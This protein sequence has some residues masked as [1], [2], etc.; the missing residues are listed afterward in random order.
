MIGKHIPTPKAG[1]SFRRLNS[2]ILSDRADDASHKVA[3]SNAINLS[4]VETATMEMEALAFQNKRCK[5]PVFHCLLSWKAGEQ[6]S[7]DQVYDAVEITLKE[8]GLSDCQAL[9]ALH[10][11]TENYHVHIA[12]NRVSPETHKA[13]DPAHGWTR[14]AMERSARK[15]EHEQGWEIENNAWTSIDKNGNT[16]GE[17]AQVFDTDKTIPQKVKD[18]EN[19]TG[20]KSAIR[21]AKEII[22]T[23]IKNINSWHD[24]H[25]FMQDKNLKYERKGS[26]AII[27][28][29][30]VK[31]KASSVSKNLSL[32][33]LEKR[34]GHF[35]QYEYRDK[36]TGK[37]HEQKSLH[38]INR[39]NNWEL[40]IEI[41]KEYYSNKKMIND[42]LRAQNIK[43]NEMLKIRQKTEREAINRISWKGRRNELNYAR[44]TLAVRQKTE[45]LDLRDS[46]KKTRKE[47]NN[48]RQ[49][50]PSYEEWLRDKNLVNDAEKWRYRATYSEYA[51]I[52]IT[53]NEAAEI[54]NHFRDI[55][56]YFAT[57]GRG[58][59]VAFKSKDNPSITAF[60][61]SGRKI[62]VKVDDESAMLAAMQLAQQKWGA[63]QLNGSDRYKEK[64]LVLAVENGIQI[65]N[66]ELQEKVKLLEAEIRKQR[67]Q[68]NGGV[69]MDDMD[70]KREYFMRYHT[71]VGADRYKVTATEIFEDGTK[72]GFMVNKKDGCPDGFTVDELMSKMWRLSSLESQGRNIYYTP[73]S[74]DKHHILIDD[75]DNESLAKFLSDGY[76]AA[77]VIES[78]PGN[79]QAVITIDKLGS[80]VD[81][82]VGNAIV[83]KLNQEY[84]DPSVS[85]EIHAHRAPGFTNRKRKH[86]RE[87][88]TFPEVV[89]SQT[90]DGICKKTQSLAKEILND[91]ITM[92]KEEAKQFKE[93]ESMASRSKDNTTIA[94]KIHLEDVLKIQQ[95]QGLN[96][97]ELDASRVDAMICIRLRATGHN[98]DDI[99]KTLLVMAPKVREYIGSAGV[100]IWTDYAK[101]TADYAFG[102]SGDLA[103]E[104]RK[105]FV[106]QWRSLENE[107]TRANRRTL[108]KGKRRDTGI[109]R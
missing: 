42:E 68:R 49:R 2:Y 36:L 18:I 88:G 25:R 43:I 63:V 87:D 58:G 92:Q 15:I 13:I 77:A 104:K 19:L 1:S 101:R 57:L 50:F 47:M 51:A 66:P 108:G 65:T 78:S 93:L 94:Y 54:Y 3:Y 31:I 23:E 29:G 53:G 75:M 67:K 106:Q 27:T 64:C 11:N 90:N 21:V 10:K 56:G 6:P 72:R 30:D 46:Q 71:A 82:A 38:D 74:D 44:S 69:D 37:I 24:L 83:A 4:S 96:K 105:K 7:K 52:V 97:D 32:T 107:T 100:H 85:G 45:R 59:V 109:G 35:E 40:Y 9:F 5:D 14:K 103:L 76:Q 20:E 89:L 28:V 26:G 91:M 70:K 33:S 98:K 95:K 61:D 86:C 22:N 60:L 8:L 84:G 62:T 73:I 16:V 80:D 17:S 12:V 34:F 102:Y 39:T 81:R 79:W 41:R 48:S 55:R 99:E